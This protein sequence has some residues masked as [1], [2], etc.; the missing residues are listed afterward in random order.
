MHQAGIENVVA[1]SG[2][3]LTKG[4]IRL[5]HRFT[6]NV[7]VLYDGDAAGIKASIRGIDMLLEEGLNIKVVL[8]PQGED[9]DSFAKSQDATQFI[10][11]IEK[12]QNDFI[13][14]KTSL[15][16]DEA[17]SDPI[18]RAALIGDSAAPCWKQMKSSFMPK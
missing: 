5:I 18:K 16:L 13:R 11:Y 3:S 9:P 10:G 15:L 2:T 7:T 6:E 17:G 8:L 4:Q 14:F 1:S 12:H